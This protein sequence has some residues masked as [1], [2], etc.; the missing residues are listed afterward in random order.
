MTSEAQARAPDPLSEWLSLRQRRRMAQRLAQAA[1][2]G[3]EVDFTVRPNRNR[4]SL[5][6]IAHPRPPAEEVCE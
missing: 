3:H 4:P 6:R 1:Q 2:A 5:L